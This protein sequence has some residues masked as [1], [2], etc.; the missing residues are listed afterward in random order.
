MKREG[1]IMKSTQ[2]RI[3]HVLG[4][5][6]RGG[7]ETMVMNLYRQIDRSKLQFDFIIHTDDECDY[8]R[9]IQSL[10]GRIYSISR[11]TGKN[12]AQYRK[13]WDVFLEKHPEYKIIHG[14]V[15]STASIYLKIAKSRGL[16]TIAHSHNT[17]SGKGLPA[18]A[19]NIL[20]FPI[21]YLA[22]YLFACSKTAGEWLYGK[23][24]YKKQNFKIL[25]NAIDAKKFIYNNR[26]R[27]I[28][29][30]EFNIEDKFVIGHIGRFHKQKNHE[31]I[32]DIFKI[33]Q[34][35]N[36]NSVLM[37]VG[38][39]DL[40]KSVQQ[41]VEKLGLVDKVI[42][43]GVRPDITELLQ[44]MDVFLFPSLFEG[45]PVTLVEAQ[46]A[47]LPCIISNNISDEIRVTSL[48]E[49]VALQKGPE[50]WAKKVLEQNKSY[51]RPN[52]Y[53]D[54]V[55]ADYDIDVVAK[56]YQDFILSK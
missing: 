22:D 1:Y 46:A 56:W 25:N 8:T 10:G 36:K 37:L 30:K 42:F 39:G 12:H 41:K 47:G 26:V 52:T 53:D 6:D 35:Y 49:S 24:V 55:K 18:F 38:D 44:S 45:L 15:R 9:E 11:Y 17:S 2:V 28:R 50:Y 40:K 23:N 3:L 13:E 14:H 27:D 54:L 34:D 32:I 4:R 5:L 48:I 7:A 21:R 51:L 33:I 19:K 43:T 29:R 20:Q 31:Y 16:I